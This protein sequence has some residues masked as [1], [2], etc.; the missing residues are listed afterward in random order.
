MVAVFLRVDYFLADL[1][2]DSGQEAPQ[3]NVYEGSKW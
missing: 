1:V 3:L 2:G